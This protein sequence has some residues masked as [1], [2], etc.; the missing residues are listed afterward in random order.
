MEKKGRIWTEGADAA[1]A[2]GA[3]FS[4]ERE[5]YLHTDQSSRKPAG[6]GVLEIKPPTESRARE[7][8]GEV[9]SGAGEGA[10]SK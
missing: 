8:C 5:K 1:V 3:V 6:R 2:R 7:G 10:S 9:E 4:R